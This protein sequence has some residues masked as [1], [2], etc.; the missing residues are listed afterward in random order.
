MPS[1]Q[2]RSSGSDIEPGEIGQWGAPVLRRVTITSAVIVLLIIVFPRFATINVC[3]AGLLASVI[4]LAVV[5]NAYS[6]SLLSISENYFQPVTLAALGFGIWSLIACAWSASPLT[7]LTKVVLYFG[8][9]GVFLSGRSAIETLDRQALHAIARGIIAGLLIGAVY[10]CVETVTSR[11]V[12]RFLWEHFESLRP[13]DP[14]HIRFYKGHVSWVSD[15]NINRVT[16]VFT[17]FLLPALLLSSGILKGRLKTVAVVLFAF[18][19][20]LLLL[21]TRHQ[22]SQIAIVAGVGLF[23][24][25]SVSVFAARQ[26][27][28]GGW[29]VA[30]ALMLPL[31]ITAYNSGLHQSSWLF[32]TAQ[33]R[34]VIWGFTAEQAFQQPIFGVGTNS[35]PALDEQ[36]TVKIKPRGYTTALETRAHPHNVYLQVWYELGAIGAFLFGLL[37]LAKIEHILVFSERA[38]P[39]ALAQLAT[40]AAIIG[41]SYGLWQT[42]FQASIVL[43]MLALVLAAKLS[44]NDDSLKS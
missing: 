43:S 2:D 25:A 33:Q 7:G 14:K 17:M 39:Y 27:A 12:T 29:I 5:S 35:T 11:G 22:T 40:T 13:D 34:V 6:R 23:A 18:T 32:Q 20:A 4:S 37:G 24:L 41:S 1:N 16:A 44:E 3:G 26:I 10:L 38:R 36:R 8:L 15:A 31:A 30:T 9:V 21:K 19:A 42:W 28:I